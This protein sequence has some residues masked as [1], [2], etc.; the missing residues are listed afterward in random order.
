MTDVLINSTKPQNREVLTVRTGDPSTT[1]TDINLTDAN[2][3]RVWSSGELAAFNSMGN[4]LLFLR[5]GSYWS[6]IWQ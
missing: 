5:P 3:A 4:V 6:F 1:A 2:L